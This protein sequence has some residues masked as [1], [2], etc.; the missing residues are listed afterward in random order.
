MSGLWRT[1]LDVSVAKICHMLL[2]VIALSVTARYLGPEGRG[3][4]A[5][6]T[7]WV[8]FFA[9]VLYLNLGQIAVHKAAS[10][11]L[12]D[13]SWL[14]EFTGVITIYLPIA[15]LIGW[16]VMGILTFGRLNPFG[17]VNPVW[18]WCGFAF[19]PFFIISNYSD[20]IFS[21][22]GQLSRLNRWLVIWQALSVLLLVITVAILDMGVGTALLITMLGFAIPNAQAA[23]YVLLNTRFKRIAIPDFVSYLKSAAPLQIGAISTFLFSSGGTLVMSHYRGE[24]E[25]GIY[26][27]GTQVISMIMVLPYTAAMV[28]YGKIA[29]E[30]ARGPWHSHRKMI[31]QVMTVV[32]SGAGLVWLSA[33]FWIT[34][35]A[36]ERFLPLLQVF[37]LQIMSLIGMIFGAMIAPQWIARGFLKTISVISVLIGV[38]SLMANL[39]FIPEYGMM[40][41]S[42]ASFAASMLVFA[43]SLGMFLYCEKDWR[44]HNEMDRLARGNEVETSR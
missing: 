1:L 29:T 15:S 18:L 40:A 16:L 6:V 32:M 4:I 35:L 8:R 2:G 44:S 31:I 20:Y 28:I 33:S 11:A 17:E 43:V 30:G 13:S 5:T 19:L 27:L 3:T 21:P 12:K 38:F 25:T 41:A 37:H 39:V 23:R 14:V 26:Q 34:L 36:G 10:K 22:L 42:W 9:V 7:T 24:T